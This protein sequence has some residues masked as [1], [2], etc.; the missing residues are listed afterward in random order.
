MTWQYSPYSF[1][2]AISAGVSIFVGILTMRRW[3]MPGSISLALF[4]LS[5]AEG[6]IGYAFEYAI[7]GI[8]GKVICAKIEYIGV[9]TAPMFFFLFALEYT[10]KDKLLNTWHMLALWIIPILTLGLVTT[11]ELHQL[12]WTSFTPAAHNMLIYGHG[13]WF[14]VYGVYTY[15]LIAIATVLLV[16]AGT[17]FP[18]HYRSRIAAILVGIFLPWIS[19]AAY[20]LRLIPIPGLDLTPAAMSMTGA[21]MA[22]S[23]FK[24]ELLNLTPVARDVLIE[25]M[26]DSVI[27]LDMQNR[28]VDINPAACR[29]FGVDKVPIGE[30]APDFLGKWPGLVTDY[31][32]TNEI[33]TEFLFG[34]EPP[35][36]LDVHISPV[37]D[38][39]KNLV[40]KLIVLRD[41]T[42]QKAIEQAERLG[43]QRLT[44]ILETVPD[45]IV[46]VDQ[47]GQ[48]TFTNPS[49]EKLFG[50][51]FS[52]LARRLYNAPEWKISAPDGSPFPEENLPFAQVMKTG[53]PVYNVEHAINHPDGRRLT[54]SINAAPLRGAD[55][56]VTEVVFTLEDITKRHLAQQIVAQKAEELGILNR[57]NLAITAGLDFDHVLKTL[58]EQCQQVVPSNVF[59]VAL[60]EEQTSLI[61]IPLY[62]EREYRPGPTL[63][64]H[65]NP[66]LTGQVIVSRQTLYLSDI[67]DGATLP[68]KSIIRT[69][70]TA[71]RSYVGIPLFLRDKVIGVMSVQAYH[72]DAY[73]DDQIHLLEN[74]AVQAA[75]AIENARLYGVVQRMAIIDE[76]TDIYNYR[77]L[78]E[79]GA[80]EVERARRFNHPL[81]AL[82]FDIDGFKDF[83]NKYSHATGN[84]VLKSVAAC[85]RAVLRSVDVIA[86]YGGDE[87]FILLPET[88]QATGKRVARRLCREIAAA[89][90][91]ADDNRLSVTISVG[92]ASLTDDI[93]D[94]LSLI[95]R[96]NQAEHVAKS[97]GNCVVSYKEKISAP[98]TGK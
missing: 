47:S 42:R 86:R 71:T 50:L 25:D 62:Y 26:K 56:G 52:D 64:I 78:L 51:S 70:R 9:T 92:L 97:Q 15:T 2:L 34:K 76:L 49:A 54:L 31:E 53:K 33:H 44:S 6:S 61:H 28:I 79:L 17:R 95:N 80:R 63:D 24:F 43:R 20:S 96:A 58:H 23:V 19:N 37:T 55:G 84:L 3:A 57:I 1:I 46:I 72:P 8:P 93:P 75:I 68:S 18:R 13:F 16:R 69:N 90:I 82:F 60:Y 39:R 40:G 77:G 81:T 74:I 27:V 87:F 67:L 36:Y 91:A 66:G 4:M 65:S 89:K 88:D 29:L 12:I 45:G 98:D 38:R 73:T 30:F 32:D 83:N 41:I 22:Y 11:N 35:S 94:I 5:V 7:I 21:I 48:I 14:W 10:R 59:Y 85:S